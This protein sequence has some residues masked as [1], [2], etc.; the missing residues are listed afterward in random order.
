MHRSRR[1]MPQGLGSGSKAI[2]IRKE[3]AITIDHLR[4][5]TMSLWRHAGANYKH[6][7]RREETMIHRRLA[8]RP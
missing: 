7:Q 5:A 3:I 2:F 4:M 1:I 6:T 8:Q